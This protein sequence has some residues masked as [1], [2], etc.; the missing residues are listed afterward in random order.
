MEI[1]N[2][3]AVF[4]TKIPNFIS[5][6]YVRD[7]SALITLKLSLVYFHDCR[8][9]M[10]DDTETQDVSPPV[11]DEILFWSSLESKPAVYKDGEAQENEAV[12]IMRG[13]D[14]DIV[15]C[16]KST[17][18]VSMIGCHFPCNLVYEQAM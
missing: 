5:Y 4:Q 13:H 6:Q 1:W 12:D 16:G 14:L 18:A 7:L 10:K 17:Y 11:G 9:H 3:N 8:N 15:K 2:M